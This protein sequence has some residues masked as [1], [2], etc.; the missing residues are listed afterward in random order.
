MRA[1]MAEPDTPTMSSFSPSF[2]MG[3]FE[4]STHRRNDGKRLDLI[5][6]TRH[7]LLAEQ[8][9]EALAAHGIRGARDGA[10]WHLIERVPGHYDWSPVLPLIRAAKK[11]GVRVAWD[12]CHY[13]HPDHVSPF[14][15]GFDADF[16]LVDLRTTTTLDE[17]TLLTCHKLVAYTG[18]ILKGCIRATYLRGQPIV[19]DGA[20]V[21]APGGKLVVPERNHS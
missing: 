21:A 15:P 5:A 6:S 13:G 9:Y 4:C 14:E 2:F 7:D 17:T 16:S 20:V 19:E 3:G 18:Q 10:R 1:R 8:D 12:V 11:A